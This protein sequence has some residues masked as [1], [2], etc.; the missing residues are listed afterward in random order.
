MT[1]PNHL[2]CE[3][4]S[5]PVY[6]DRLGNQFVFLD[7]QPDLILAIH[8][9][10]VSWVRDQPTAPHPDG[11]SFEAP[12]VMATDATWG[13]VALLA[14]PLFGNGTGKQPEEKK[15]EKAL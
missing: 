14:G 15:D 3:R 11:A 9:C 5:V 10:G 2:A 6:E 4:W 1:T 7:R 12:H 13:R 8:R